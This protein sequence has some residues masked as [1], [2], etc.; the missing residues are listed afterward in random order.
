MIHTFL[1]PVFDVCYSNF[2]IILII[3]I[4][5]PITIVLIGDTRVAIQI[6]LQCLEH[7]VNDMYSKFPNNKD[8]LQGE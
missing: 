6:M 1:S 7:T 2:I 5:I 4:H 8:D 3:T